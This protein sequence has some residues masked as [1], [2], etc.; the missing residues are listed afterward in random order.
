MKKISSSATLGGAPVHK[1][2]LRETFNDEIWDVIEAL[3]SPYNSD[4]E[5]IIVSGCEITGSGPYDIAAGIVYLNGEFMRLAAATGQ[6]LPKYI[7]AATA[8][9]DTRTFNDG[10][11]AA[12][13]VTKSAE[14]AG[15]APGSGQYIAITS[16]TDPDDR[17]WKYPIQSAARLKK[18]VVLIGDWNMDS[19]SGVSV[20]HGLSDFTKIRGIEVIIIDDAGTT[21]RS[22]DHVSA[23]S[24]APDG[25]VNDV[26][27]TTIGLGRFSTGVFDGTAY[28][29]TSYNR[30]WITITYED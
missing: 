24:S 3:L 27:S 22:L 30:G 18:K 17:R 13:F 26:N 28:D 12:V 4:T 20:N 23:G 11:S 21:L 2:D 19:I 16:T 29:Q 8:V 7:Q 14:L 10:T 6:T 5:G 9:N 15:S 1:G 25:G